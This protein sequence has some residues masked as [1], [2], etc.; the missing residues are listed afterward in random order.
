MDKNA[1]S[2][3]LYVSCFGE[4]VYFWILKPNKSVVFRQTKLKESA[5]QV[6]GNEKIG[7][8]R[9][10]RQEQCED[11]SLFSSYESSLAKCHAPQEGG[12]ATLRLVE[13]DNDTPWVMVTI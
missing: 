7:C 12:T 9:L 2:S 3:C 10:L 13:E 8:F 11:R 5:D 6:F 1:L 4:D